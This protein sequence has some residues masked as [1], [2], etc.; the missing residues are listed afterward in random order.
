MYDTLLV[1]SGLFGS[2]VA[3]E[4]KEHG[5]HVIVLG[6]RKHIGGNIY[7]EDKEGI[8]VHVYGPHVFHTS[9]R[10]IWNYVN[11][12]IFFSH[13]YM[14]RLFGDIVHRELSGCVSHELYGS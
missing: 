11:R 8:T 7:T 1:G 6:C 13:L 9:K 12:L 4:L 2:I 10:E 5:K 14:N 3:Y